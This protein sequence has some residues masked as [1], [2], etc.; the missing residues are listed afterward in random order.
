M[1]SFVVVLAGLNKYIFKAGHLGNQNSLLHAVDVHK[2]AKPTVADN[3]G[4]IWWLGYVV[5]M[6]TLYPFVSQST[7]TAFNAALLSISLVGFI[8]LID[9]IIGISWSWKS[10]SPI[11][12]SI[13]LAIMRVGVT[14]MEVPLVGT[15][16]FGILY[17]LI[18]API[19]V[20]AC[21]N[22][23]NMLAGLNGLEAG[24]CLISSLGLATAAL[25]SGHK[26][27]LAIL[28]PYIS[29]MLA[30]LVYNR[31]PSRVFPGDV[32]TL[33]FGAVFASFGILANM[34][35]AVLIALIPYTLNAAL[36]LIG[37]WT[38]HKPETMMKASSDGGRLVF[39]SKNPYSLRSLIAR[40]VKA[41]E[42]T[43]VVII[44]IIVGL[45]AVL[46]FFTV[47]LRL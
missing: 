4:M 20:T 47:S 3:G 16:D 35:K 28:I 14:T 44:W 32:G 42:K 18:V 39:I 26:I 8:G 36:I 1:V 23:T 9:D 45:F 21:S 5:G 25:A 7:Q 43:T 34:E 41:D 12:G 2:L 15:V 29:A 31:Y 40:I 27:G 17:F 30:F 38:G 33:S 19:A 6:L 37:S 13:P 24:S 46:A 11:L 22:V 10:I